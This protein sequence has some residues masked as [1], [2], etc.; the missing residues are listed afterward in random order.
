ML[1]IIV[2][3][4]T[5]ILI[6]TSGQILLYNTENNQ[7]I[8][9]FDCLYYISENGEKIPYCRRLKGNRSLVRDRKRCENQ[10]EMKL[11]RSLLEQKIEPSY[12]L[13]WS[14]SI[15]M[16]DIYANFFY[17]QSQIEPNDNQFLCQCIKAG[18]FGKYCEYK[19]T[20]NTQSFDEVLKIQFKQKKIDSWNTQRYGKI[21]CYNTLRCN[22]SILCLDWQE[23]CDGIQRCESGIDEEN[24]D[25]LEFNEC[26]DDEFR[27]S[28]G[29]CIPEQSWL[30]GKY[31]D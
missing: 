11:F 23:I 26:E 12:V 31:R 15:E 14:S 20:H 21:L 22:L 28:N 16:A 5:L 18:T 17:N 27:C 13:S 30:D 10:G 25:L 29:M 19:L 2:G 7:T 4:L 8:E 3:I 6:V 9:K 24:C 1:M